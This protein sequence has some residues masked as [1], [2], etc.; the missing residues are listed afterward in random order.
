MPRALRLTDLQGMEA[1]AYKLEAIS[2]KQRSFQCA[3]QVRAVGRRMPC[4][5][6]GRISILAWSRA[7]HARCAA[8][9]PCHLQDAQVVAGC[10][11]SAHIAARDQANLARDEAM[12]A[13]NQAIVAGQGFQQLLGSMC[14]VTRLVMRCR[15]PACRSSS[16]CH[17]LLL[18][19]RLRNGATLLPPHPTYTS[20]GVRAAAGPGSGAAAALCGPRPAA[21][22][23]PP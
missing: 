13:L 6:V 8:C 21:G 1:T 22:D 15:Q 11:P 7:T 23:W 18:A 12:S 9:L 20:A 10:E 2:P 3:V 16:R 19:R 14:Q 17:T 5:G 4:S